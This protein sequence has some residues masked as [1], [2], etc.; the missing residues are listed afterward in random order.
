MI[1]IILLSFIATLIYTPVGSLTCQSKLNKIIDYEDL[2]RSLIYS[3]VIF[4]FIA[5]IINFFYPLNKL[6]NTLVLFIP[7]LIL[8]FFKKYY[9]NSK[10]F[11]FSIIVSIITFILITKSNTYRPDAGLYHLPYISILNSDKI[12]F[13]LSSL[14]FRFGHTSI[15]QHTSAIFN[16]LIFSSN[17]IVL[18]AAL[19]YSAVVINFISQI[20]KYLKKNNYNLHLFFLVFVTI[21]V[22]V[23]MVRY[24]EFGNDIPSH[25]LFLFL[26]SEILKN[27]LNPS[28]DE[29]KNFFIISIFIILNKIFLIVSLLIPF[30]FIKKNNIKKIFLSKKALFGSTFLLL[31][32]F[33]NIIVSGCIIYPMKSTCLESIPWTDLQK[34]EIV[35]NESAAWA[36]SWS[37]HKNEISHSDYMKNF[38]WLKTW[39]KNNGYKTFKIIFPYIIFLFFISILLIDNKNN[40]N[41]LSKKKTK[42]SKKI[43]LF[44]F[45][46]ILIWLIK[47]PDYRYGT[48][49][50]VGF[51]ALFF[52]LI[53][54]KSNLRKNLSPFIF[55]FLIL[56]F[57]FFITKNL[58]RIILSDNNYVNYPW[59]KYY[60]HGNDNKYKNPRKI[61][62]NGKILYKADGPC[63]YGLSPC[64]SQ[65][66]NFDVERKFNYYFFIKK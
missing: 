9:F 5:L 52:S 43:L 61:E 19:I 51:I 34:I 47:A 44:S 26:I 4:S 25:L 27:D 65:I 54:T 64:S 3:L 49:Y 40:S 8:F 16:N 30:L 22:L 10:Y 50:I 14:H 62:V 35:S 15:I 36:K 42:L 41:K 17:G 2:S 1:H 7:A 31:W 32:M 20:Y 58:K 60:S 11:L 18:P 28:I 24:S 53:V 56:S 29:I 33:K 66:I 39:S 37:S 57:S 48:G 45:L 46:G 63:M 38:T 13:G 59:P 55:S 23:K 12:I 6:I 21:F